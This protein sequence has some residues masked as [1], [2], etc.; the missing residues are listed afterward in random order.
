MD[1][2]TLLDRY[3]LKM[4]LGLY[5][6]LPV[7]YKPSVSEVVHWLNLTLTLVLMERFQP[8]FVIANALAYAYCHAKEDNV[9]I[10]IY[11][12]VYSSSEMAGNVKPDGNKFLRSG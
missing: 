8:A 4:Y 2:N 7:V 5:R 10:Y 3:G 11:V 1:M 12:S 6:S 9:Y